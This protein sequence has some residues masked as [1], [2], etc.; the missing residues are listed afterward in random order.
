MAD[1]RYEH[2]RAALAE[3]IRE[4][5]PVAD[6]ASDAATDAAWRIA[7][8]HAASLW[9]DMGTEGEGGER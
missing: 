5:G 6:K 3:L 1:V 7:T 9:A 8:E 4:H 2:F